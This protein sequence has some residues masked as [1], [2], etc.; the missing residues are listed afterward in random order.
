MKNIT[1]ALENE[2]HLGYMMFVNF[3]VPL[4]LT[5][6]HRAYAACWQL[7][8]QKRSITRACTHSRATGPARTFAHFKTKFVAES[9]YAVW[10]ELEQAIH[11]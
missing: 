4:K 8:D 3:I 5:W 1:S 2:A 11:T 6:L 10:S 7:L 9:V